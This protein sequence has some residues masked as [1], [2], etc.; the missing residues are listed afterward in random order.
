M[1]H[2]SQLSDSK[3]QD[4]SQG[5][6][7]GREKGP[8][9]SASGGTGG[10]KIKAFPDYT[11][12]HSVTWKP[13]P[14]ATKSSWRTD[15]GR[16]WTLFWKPKGSSN[17]F[18]A[19]TWFSKI[20]EGV[21]RSLREKRGQG[22]ISLWLSAMARSALFVHSSL[23]ASRKLQWNKIN[24]QSYPQARRWLNSC[25]TSLL[26]FRKL[27]LQLAKRPVAEKSQSWVPG[28]PINTREHSGGERPG[29]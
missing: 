6:A 17:T 20:R 13:V 16:Y 7:P 19:K 12:L 29:W 24:F 14:Q 9:W 28:K 26:Y 11:K 4:Q 2:L 23:K 15:M 21:L 22:F 5:A 18:W 25:S 1:S 3:Q 10:S 27:S 8:R